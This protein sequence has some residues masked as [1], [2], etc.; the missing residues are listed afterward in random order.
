MGNI[1]GMDPGMQETREN[2]TKQQREM[3]K[4]KYRAN[5]RKRAGTDKD[6]KREIKPDKGQTFNLKHENQPN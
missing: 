3:E 1:S 2:Q 5:E 6:R 4:L